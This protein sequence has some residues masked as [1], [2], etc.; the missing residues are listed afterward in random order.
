[1]PGHLVDGHRAARRDGPQRPPVAQVQAADVGAQRRLG[2]RLAGRREV[3]RAR[4]AGL[5]VILRAGAEHPVDGDA[6]P[7]ARQHRHRD[8]RGPAD[9]PGRRVDR[10]GRDAGGQQG[11]VP[12][13]PDRHRRGRDDAAPVTGRQPG[14]PQPGRRARRAPR[15][16]LATGQLDRRVRA[17]GGGDRA[18]IAPADGGRRRRTAQ[19]REQ[20]QGEQQTGAPIGGDRGTR[21]RRRVEEGIAVAV[22]LDQRHATPFPVRD[23]PAPAV[24]SSGYG[25]SPRP[26]PRRRPA[27]PARRSSIG[28]PA[29]SAPP[30]T[31]PH[32]RAAG[33]SGEAGRRPGRR[34]RP[35]YARRR[36]PPG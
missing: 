5:L 6:D 28:R 27:P 15:I 31:P 24:S 33:R 18:E 30:R 11:H 4:I 36:A 13:R 21:G 14:G 10:G 29:A 20:D 34:P 9:P 16:D 26:P 12:G 32:R 19:D 23:Q 17:Q 35:W 3:E 22:Q 7:T 2:V 1:M 25:I 8:R